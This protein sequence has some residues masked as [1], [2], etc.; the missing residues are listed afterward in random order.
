MMRRPGDGTGSGV[1]E[2]RREVRE[3]QADGTINDQIAMLE[4]RIQRVLRELKL[5]QEVI[6]IIKAYEALGTDRAATPPITLRD[7]VNRFEISLLRRALERTAGNQIRAAKS[8]GLNV[9]TL[10][11]M[12]KRYQINPLD[13]SATADS[14]KTHQSQPQEK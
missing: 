11:S 10:N 12:I 13:Y 2:K 14:R 3:K 7:M 1:R 5:L 6:E 9:T 8:L 4:E